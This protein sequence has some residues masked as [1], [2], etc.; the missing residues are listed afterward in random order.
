MDLSKLVSVTKLT[1]DLENR[2]LSKV[3]L[4][5]TTGRAAIKKPIVKKVQTPSPP[6]QSL[7]KKGFKKPAKPNSGFLEN[8]NNYVK[9]VLLKVDLNLD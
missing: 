2:P 3:H 7:V 9:S 4:P 1:R 8:L 6:S 5:R